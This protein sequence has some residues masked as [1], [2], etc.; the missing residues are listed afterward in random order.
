L[1]TQEASDKFLRETITQREEIY[2]VIL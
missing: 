2:P 1:V